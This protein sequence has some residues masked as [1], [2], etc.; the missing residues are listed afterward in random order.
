MSNIE[1][2]SSF[3]HGDADVRRFSAALEEAVQDVAEKME[4]GSFAD[5]DVQLSVRVFRENPGRIEGYKV[6]LSQTG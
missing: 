6:T 1:G 2:E 4:Q 5:F 3:V